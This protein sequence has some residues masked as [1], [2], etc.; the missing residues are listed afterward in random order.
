MVVKKVIDL[1]T[2]D[3][4]RAAYM[5]VLKKVLAQCIEKGQYF[6]PIPHAD[7]KGEV[8]RAVVKSRDVNTVSTNACSSQ[9]QPP[10]MWC[11]LCQYHF[12]LT[13]ITRAITCN[14]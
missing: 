5:C 2:I 11:S 6:A 8:P 7:E 4:I 13:F 12:L 14:V 9:R 3:T 1:M 10:I